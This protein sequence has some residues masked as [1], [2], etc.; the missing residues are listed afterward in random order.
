MRHVQDFAQHKISAR[1]ELRSREA[2]VTM[3]GRVCLET[4]AVVMI[5]SLWPNW[6][7]E[8]ITVTNW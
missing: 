3:R 8:C 5:H 6:T 4:A 1:P 2:V 7:R